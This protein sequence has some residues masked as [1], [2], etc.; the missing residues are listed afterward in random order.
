MLHTFRNI[1]FCFKHSIFKYLAYNLSVE[2][3]LSRERESHPIR[4]FNNFYR[5]LYNL[6]YLVSSGSLVISLLYM[7]V[8]D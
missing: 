7:L 5:G 6:P 8:F 3:L 2:H 1:L 4:K